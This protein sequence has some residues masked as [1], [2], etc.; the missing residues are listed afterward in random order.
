MRSQASLN[1]VSEALA[2]CDRLMM[3]MNRVHGL[4]ARGSVDGSL[5]LAHANILEASRTDKGSVAGS[6]RSPEAG[7]SSNL[8][9][10]EDS[11]LGAME[12]IRHVLSSTS[13][14]R[15]VVNDVLDLTK[16][17]AGKLEV[18]SH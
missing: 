4:T 17:E 3:M 13:I 11:V 1:S 9:L 16:I 15:S 2:A 6:G 8:K 5:R 10:A 7:A 12:D 18:C 14:L